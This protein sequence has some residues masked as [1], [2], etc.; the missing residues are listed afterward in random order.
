[1]FSSLSNQLEKISPLKGQLTLESSHVDSNT[2]NPDP[3]NTER[4]KIKFFLES[5]SFFKL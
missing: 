1:M 5:R 2:L 4:E 3:R